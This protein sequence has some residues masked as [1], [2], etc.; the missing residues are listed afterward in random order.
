[1]ARRKNATKTRAA[2]GEPA[3]PR[4]AQPAAGRKRNGTGRDEAVRQRII[5]AA[6]EIY[7]EYGTSAQAWWISR[8]ASA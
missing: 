4:R 1:M 7:R 6:A 2:G 3:R 5:R 8:A